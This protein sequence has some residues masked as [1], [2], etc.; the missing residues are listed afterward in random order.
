MLTYKSDALF[1]ERFGRRPDRGGGDP[2]A[3]A[4]DRFDVEGYL[5]HQGRIFSPR[6][7]ANAYLTL[8]RAMDLFD[9][10]DAAI[11]PQTAETVFVGIQ[12]DW[13]FPAPYV[14]AA[15]ERFAANGVRSTYLEMMSSHG[16]DAF[17]AEPEVLAALLRPYFV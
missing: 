1:A 12:N 5:D 2:Y 10:R 9:V 17:L 8:T 16:H 7:D 15:A 13:L 6:M 3:A 11:G 4:T 14:R